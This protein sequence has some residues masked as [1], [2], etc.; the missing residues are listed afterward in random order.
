MADPN[1][2]SSKDAVN[3]YQKVIDFIVP[4]RREIL[5]T[6]AKLAT[7]F[8]QTDLKVLDIGCGDGAV[9]TEI[10]K[11]NP[12]SSVWMVDNS[13]EMIRISQ[14]R[15]WDNSNIRVR[16]FDLNNGLPPETQAEKFDVVV[17]C[18]ALHHLEYENRVQ[19]YKA[20]YQVLNQGAFFVN[21]DMFR[22]DSSQ[23]NDWEF[24]NWIRWMVVKLKEHLGEEHT[25]DEIKQ[26]QLASFQ[27]M[28]DKPGTLWD[29]YHDLQ[30]A[31]FVKVDCMMK[32]QNLAIMAATKEL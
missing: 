31:G 13:P 7:D 5:E 22:G 17:S 27:K 20:I 30:S 29:M 10:L 12:H 28:G 24:D 3:R 15:F 25:F 6:I 26:R 9:T 14:E 2:W 32:V 23:M 18:F 21:G 8:K 1:G 16:Q 19:L 11:I 4:G